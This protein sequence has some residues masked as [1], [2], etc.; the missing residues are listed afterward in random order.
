MLSLR[1][2]WAIALCMLTFGRAGCMAEPPVAVG[3]T[4]DGL[5]PCPDRPNCVSSYA[6]DEEKR[7]EPIP[8]SGSVEEGRR[9]LVEILG[10]MERAEVIDSDGRYLHAIDRSA[11]FGFVDDVEFLIDE[12]AGVIHF[13][14]GAR[15]GYDDLDVN[16]KRMEEIRERFISP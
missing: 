15:L 12:E 1:E 11:T 10:T 9:R 16:R 4:E 5:A 2:F 13:R 14:S 8:F 3:V 6:E 7:M